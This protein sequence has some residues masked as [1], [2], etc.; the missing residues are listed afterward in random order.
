M[1][2]STATNMAATVSFNTSMALNPQNRRADCEFNAKGPQNQRLKNENGEKNRR[3][4]EASR[5]KINDLAGFSGTTAA[6]ATASFGVFSG[7]DTFGFETKAVLITG[8]GVGGGGAR[9]STGLIS[10]GTEASGTG[11]GMGVVV[12]GVV[13]A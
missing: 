2:N 12:E 8:V 9:D 3:P 13:V 4:T 5:E 6:S 10:S 1:T 7:M 11:A